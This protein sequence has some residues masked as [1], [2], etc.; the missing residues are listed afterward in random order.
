MSTGSRII[1]GECLETMRG[2]GDC[3][4]DAIVTDPPYGLAFMGAKWDTF[5]RPKPYGNDS[6][7]VRR[8]KALAYADE[9][10]GAPRY[11][12]GHGT[13][14]MTAVQALDFQTSMTPI[15]SEA[16]RVAKCG[17]YLLCF[18]GTRTFHRVA[19]AIEDAGWEIRDT[20]MW[21]YGS[22]FPKSMDV[23]KAVGKKLDAEQAERWNG[24]G[25]HLKPAWEPIIVARKPLDGTVAHNVMEHGVGALNI[26]GCR[27][28]T[29][30]RTYGGMSTKQPTGAGCFRDDNWQPK[31]MSKTVQGRFPAN[32]VHDGSQEVLEL[33]PNTG[34][35][36]GGGM[37][38]KG[39]GANSQTNA[40]GSYTGGTATESVGFG[41]D[42]SAAR[43]FYCAKASKRDR[44]EG[45][46]HPT[47]KPTALMRWLVRLVCPIGGTVL[48]PF[49]GSGS[50]GVA[51]AIEGMG[52][53]GIDTD[54][55][56]CE[57][58]EKRITDAT[59]ILGNVQTET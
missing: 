2:M 29:E 57:I 27:V 43:F 28:G 44:G 9:H 38:A 12:N 10:K 39:V 7:E 45:N 52:F 6:M 56:Y 51:A 24:W 50:T 40:Y 19:C 8:E 58:A 33:F 11:G 59:G 53:V 42:G 22:G 34:R 54:G 36:S 46:D 48:D 55:H 3:S 23:G 20:I 1:N 17:A 13:G 21:V 14:R 47:V 31:E 18:G 4:V 25:T 15:F 41:D 5:G 26:D 32:L 16:L 37:H 35:S 49:M 30:V